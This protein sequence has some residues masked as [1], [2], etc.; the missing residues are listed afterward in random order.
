M[1]LILPL[2][3][4]LVMGLYDFCQ[5]IYAN[6]VITNM[7]REGAN[8]AV[9]TGSTPTDIMNALA[10]TASQLDMPDNGMIYVT[11][12]LRIT[13][14]PQDKRSKV[15]EQYRWVGTNMAD[16][17]DS[18]IWNCEGNG[19]SNW[20]GDACQIIPNLHSENRTAEIDL[21]LRDNEE[22]VA[23]EIFY[24]YKPLFSFFLKR[25]LNLYSTTML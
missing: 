6:N 23:V 5:A 13:S 18:H 14:G 7:S 1:A 24:V 21:T 9:R 25:D 11:K 2:L 4:V 22:V 15:L 20:V 17:P 10:A 19:S 12:I 3:V 16:P 8:L